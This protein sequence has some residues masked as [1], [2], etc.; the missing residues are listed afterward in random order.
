MRC[1][2]TL[3]T[4]VGM[5]ASEAALTPLVRLRRAIHAA[6]DVS[7]HEEGTARTIVAWL[8]R[9]ASA[10]GARVVEHG[11]GAATTAGDVPAADAAAAGSAHSGDGGGGGGR[12]TD[13]GVS[14]HLFTG[15]G[16]HGVG[17]VIDA[18][19]PKADS[20]DADAT[21]APMP[22]VLLR[23]E[24]DAL[25]LDEA[26]GRPYGSKVPGCAHQCGHDGHMACVCGAVQALLVDPPERGCVVA[27]FQPSEETGEGAAAV[28][29][30]ERWPLLGREPDWAFALHN[31]PSFPVSSVVVLDGT[32]ALASRG[33]EAVW[34][35]RTSHAAHPE[36][37]ASPVDA[38]G[39]T[40]AAWRDIALAEHG[41]GGA[42]VTIVHASLG[43]R[44]AFGVSPGSAVL[45][46]TMRAESDARVAELEKMCRDA[47][48]AAPSDGIDD[49]RVSVREPFNATVN[50]KDA[51]RIIEEVAAES[52]RG[53]GDSGVSS[54]E[55]PEEAF[56][57]SED[58]G[59]FTALEGCRGAMFG[60]G[61]GLL[62]GAG[63]DGTQAELHH[64]DYDFPEGAIAVGAAMLEQC[65]RK[66]LARHSR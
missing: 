19:P 10:V 59:L 29:A 3:C 1:C 9:E 35:G 34:T 62:A 16:G 65:A 31:V 7:G 18:A 60:L 54:T 44:S 22:T 46:A 6:P 5:A 33:L 49:V 57:W 32:F 23:C 39:H 30:D 15:L 52:Q 24:L 13:G 21:E 38:L 55:R 8:R 27:L 56:R 4:P 37:G 53:G 2:R 42:V 28:L 41:R 40:L 47:V 36:H 14:M 61:S 64:P 66:A 50:H 11:N 58:F 63:G 51:V 48:A 43:E 20:A 25:P 12:G 45:Q 26:P 17:V